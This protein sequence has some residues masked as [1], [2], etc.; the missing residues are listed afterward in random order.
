MRMTEQNPS[1]TR[2]VFQP[3]SATPEPTM[4]DGLAS[5]LIKLAPQLDADMPPVA[6][7][8]PAGSLDARICKLAVAIAATEYNVSHGLGRI[9]VGV[10]L[11][12]AVGTVTVTG[13]AIKPGGT[14]WTR[15][16]IYIKSTANDACTLTLLV[17]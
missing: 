2:A 4:V 3:N 5:R 6:A 15:E 10:I 8:C 17:F 12:D 11:I 9:P 13:I 7:N 14:A 16:K 1:G